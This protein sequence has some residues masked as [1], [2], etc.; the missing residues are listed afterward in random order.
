MGKRSLFN[1]HPRTLIYDR[2]I[3]LVDDK[4]ATVSSDSD[5]VAYAT[6]KAQ[7]TTEKNQFAN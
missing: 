4:L 6:L 3:K 7:I 1:W 2:A 5:L